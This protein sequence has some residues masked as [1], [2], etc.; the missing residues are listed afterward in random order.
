MGPLEG[1]LPC[2]KYLPRVH[3]PGR[4]WRSQSRTPLKLYFYKSVWK[5]TYADSLSDMAQPCDIDL[6]VMKWRSAWPTGIFHGL[7]YILKTI[8]CM[9]MIVWGNDSVWMSLDYLLCLDCWKDHIWPWHIGLRWAIV[10]NISRR[11][12]FFLE[13]TRIFLEGT[14]YFLEGMRFFLEQKR[15]FLKR[16]RFFLEGTKLWRKFH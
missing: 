5:I 2:H 8:W 7:P 14:R 1:V 11:N 6:W 10:E 15:K 12:E 3:A 9:R 4:G 13:E 16:T